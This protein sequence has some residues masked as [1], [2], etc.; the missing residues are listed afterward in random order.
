M[1]LEPTHKRVILAVVLSTLTTT[2]FLTAQGTTQIAA[3]AILDTPPSPDA[4]RRPARGRGREAAAPTRDLAAMGR[5]ILQ[6]NIFD[7]TTGAIS[8]DPPPPPVEV[9]D[10]G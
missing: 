2:S 5:A 9:V 4:D 8:W 7:S 6:R 10:T 1:A 3:S